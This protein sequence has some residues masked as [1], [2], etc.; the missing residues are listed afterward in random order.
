MDVLLYLQPLG[1]EVHSHLP[2]VHS[3]AVQRAVQNLA[4]GDA[5]LVFYSS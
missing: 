5:Q 1:R 4:R 3:F 2:E